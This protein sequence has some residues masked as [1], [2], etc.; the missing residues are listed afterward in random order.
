MSAITLDKAICFGI[1][2]KQREK[3]KLTSIHPF[4]AGLGSIMDIGGNGNLIKISTNNRKG[5]INTKF[6]LG[7]ARRHLIKAL[8][9]DKANEKSYRVNMKDGS[10][11]IIE[12]R[13]LD[14]D[15]KNS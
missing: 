3:K 9:V 11:R 6:P 8:E 13:G 12:L 5:V 4:M 10:V 7:I 14:C 2:G 15:K 1:R